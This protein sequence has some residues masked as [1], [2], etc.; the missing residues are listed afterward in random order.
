MK[1]C[2]ENDDVMAVG[3]KVVAKEGVSR[4]GGRERGQVA[5]QVASGEVSLL[6][7]ARQ[8]S[9]VTSLGRGDVMSVLITLVDVIPKWIKLGYIVDLGELGRL[10][11]RLKA[12]TMP[13]GVDY[14]EECIEGVNVRFHAGSELKEKL[15]DVKYRRVE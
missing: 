12:K 10:Q 7:L 8:M 5:V 2:T 3:Y 14:P 6:D 11:P 13:L 15:K 9:E 1:L 4:G